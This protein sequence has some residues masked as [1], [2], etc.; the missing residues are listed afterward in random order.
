[1]AHATRR[2]S[3]GRDHG[4]SEP[5]WIGRVCDFRQHGRR[6]FSDGH[7]RSEGAKI[8]AGKSGC[9]YYKT[10]SEVALQAPAGNGADPGRSRSRAVDGSLGVY[11]QSGAILA[12]GWA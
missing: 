7:F 11:A 12:A 10:G 8:D 2:A 1:M 6:S 5:S 4:K 3:A 9:A